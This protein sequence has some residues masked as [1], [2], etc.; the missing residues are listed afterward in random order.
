MGD[1]NQSLL[2]NIFIQRILLLEPILLYLISNQF[3]NLRLPKVS[4]N[5]LIK[6]N[7]SIEKNPRWETR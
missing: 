6:N 4:I 7:L 5:K 2:D 1:I 3:S